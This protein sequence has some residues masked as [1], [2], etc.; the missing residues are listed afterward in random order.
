MEYGKYPFA[1]TQ[2]YALLLFLFVL[3]HFLG[4]F[5]PFAFLRED[6]YIYTRRLPALPLSDFDVPNVSLQCITLRIFPGPFVVE[7]CL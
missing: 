3:M 7:A 4:E 6:G 1:D 5:P 2:L